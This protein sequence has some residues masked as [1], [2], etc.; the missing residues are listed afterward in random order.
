M[1]NS[2]LPIEMEGYLT[3]LV[4]ERGRSTATLKAYRADLG[5]WLAW[6][7]QRQTDPLSASV[8]DVVEYGAMLSDSGLADTSVTRMLVTVRGAY[9]HLAAEGVIESDPTVEVELPARP[10]ALP[11]ALSEEEVTAILDAVESAAGTG[12]P[13]AIRDS[14]LLEFLYATGARVSEVCGLDFAGLDLDAGLARLMG[15]RSKER[16]VPVGR[17]ALRAIRNYLD[18]GRE[19]MIGGREQSRSDA[20]AVFL[21]VRGRRI[22]RQAVWRAIREWSTAAGLAQDVSPH[23]MRHSCA[24]HLLDN[25]ADIRTV[26]EMLGHASVSTTQIYTRVATRRLFEAYAGAH[27]RAR[28]TAGSPGSGT[29]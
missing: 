17:P 3:H 5:R 6:L 9:R 7:H 22:S 20:V 24:T 28:A 4:V 19:H 29:A 1:I 8:D 23:V 15:K 10:D 12:D 26:A 25:G 11:K 21:G 14:A 16:V 13:L 18:V 2:E 27:P